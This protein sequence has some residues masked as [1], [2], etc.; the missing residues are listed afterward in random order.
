MDATV[1]SGGT[2]DAAGDDGSSSGDDGGASGNTASWHCFNWADQGDNFQNGALVLT[3]MSAAD[4]YATVLAESNAILSGFQSVLGAN[5]VRIPINETTANTATTWAAY[6]GVIDAAISQN[7]K[8]MIG[9]WLP[10][11]TNHIPDTTT[12]YAMWQ[13]VVNAYATNEFVYFDVFNEPSGY[14][15]TDFI[16]LVVN[17]K[18]QYPTVPPDHIVV[19]GTTTD[20]DVNVQGADPR[21]TA[22]YLNI[23]IYDNGTETAATAEANL[24]THVGPYYYRTIVSEYA[25]GTAFLTGLTT[26]MKAWEMGS[27]FWAGL[28]GTSGIAKLNGTAPNYTLTVNNASELTLIQSGWS[29]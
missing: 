8:I 4:S 19:A 5:S 24:R 14:S 20:I 3:G 23:H 21:L 29:P 15:A 2:A 17:W 22:S 9:Y 1:D 26:Q 27:C 13:V 25:G 6:K 7:M 11:G 18:A 10:P 16:T 28:E 12:W